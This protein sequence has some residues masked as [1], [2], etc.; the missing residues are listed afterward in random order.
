M[1]SKLLAVLSAALVFVPLLSQQRVADAIHADMIYMDGSILTG[2]HLRGDDPSSTPGRVT[3]LAISK[4]KIIGVGSDAEVLR[5]KGPKTRF[6]DLHGAF[7]MPGFNDAHVHMADAG[8]QKLSID[9]D[10]VPSLA[11]MLRIVEKYAAAKPPGAWLRGGGWDHTLWPGKQLPTR[12]DLDQVTGGRPCFL[13]R[14]DGHMA[15]ANSA[16]LAAAG[17]TAGTP[18]P[19][20][21]KIDRDAQGEPT[22]ILRETAATRLVLAKIPP[23]SPEDRRKALDVAIADALSHGVT[24]VQ[25]FSDWDDFLV[26]E[27]MERS[28]TLKIRFFR[29]DGFYSSACHAGKPPIEPSGERSSAPS[30]HVEGLHGWIARVP[31]RC[32]G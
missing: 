31:H 2:T 32:D 10:G 20:G 29:V 13:W 22:G 11:A 7:L 30:G 3:A 16:A 12:Q 26:L 5:W 15:V 23:P 25:D 27:S 8:Q 17:I 4:G 1:T 18:D 24:S 9:L 21:A 19:E 28:R 6:V 14:T